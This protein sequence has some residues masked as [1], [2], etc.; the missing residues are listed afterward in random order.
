MQFVG[1]PTE[2][3]LTALERK[4]D[5]EPEYRLLDLE[6]VQHPREITAVDRYQVGDLARVPRTSGKWS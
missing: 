2:P 6:L 4:L 3:E 1:S 5:F